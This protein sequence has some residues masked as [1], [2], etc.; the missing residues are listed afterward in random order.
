ML[1]L[2]HLPCITLFL[3]SNAKQLVPILF[4]TETV[5]A[6]KIIVNNR[7]KKGALV[8]SDY[9]FTYGTNNVLRG[10]DTLQQIV[11]NIDMEKP[12][13]V[14]PTRTR[15]HVACMMQLLDMTEGELTWLTSHMGHTNNIHKNWYRKEDSTIELT[16][17]ARTLM[18][19]DSHN[20]EHLQ[21]K[22]IDELG[23]F[24]GI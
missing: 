8:D 2:F 13:L 4:T 3:G 5:K 18:S 16:K 17:V 6:I 10:W 19:V 15:K 23:P 1:Y 11:K 24:E 7:Q 22:K 21:N 14:T 20:R 9:L 12:K